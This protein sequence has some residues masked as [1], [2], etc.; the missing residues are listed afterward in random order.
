MQ[1][2]VCVST[3]HSA[4]VSRHPEEAYRGGADRPRDDAVMQIG[5]WLI[6]VLSGG[7]GRPH[8]LPLAATEL[9]M[10]SAGWDWKVREGSEDSLLSVTCLPRDGLAEGRK[11][12]A[13]PAGCPL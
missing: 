3:Q 1:E 5:C 2:R 11:A 6:S 4:G 12:R 10:L 8:Q 9:N 7:E 13:G